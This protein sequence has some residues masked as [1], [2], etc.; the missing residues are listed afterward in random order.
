MFCACMENAPN[1]SWWGL[2]KISLRCPLLR[3]LPRLLATFIVEKFCE[4]LDL[5]ETLSVIL[6]GIVIS[7]ENTGDFKWAWNLTTSVSEKYVRT[8][9]CCFHRRQKQVNSFTLECFI[10]FHV[11][12]LRVLNR[13]LTMK[14]IIR[15]TRFCAEY[16]F[17][18]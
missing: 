16:L 4:A 6:M 17:A 8:L 5:F 10:A 15:P 11:G 13:S 1:I 9:N 18:T 12:L 14:C 3:C 2:Y 7:K